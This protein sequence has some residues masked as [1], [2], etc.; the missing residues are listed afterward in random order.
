VQ[1][2]P[3]IDVGENAASRA[4]IPAGRFAMLRSS[5]GFWRSRKPEDDGLGRRSCGR[6]QRC[7]P[8]PELL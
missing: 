4:T 5:T 6:E 1:K 2:L 7:L 8:D 3:F